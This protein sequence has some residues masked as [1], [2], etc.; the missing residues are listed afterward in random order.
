MTETF[1][2][3]GVV[4]T[5]ILPTLTK[6]EKQTRYFQCSHLAARLLKA[7]VTQKGVDLIINDKKMKK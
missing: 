3:L 7:Q 2:M 5:A 4:S 6:Q 1:Y